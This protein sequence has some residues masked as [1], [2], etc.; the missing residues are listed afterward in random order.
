MRSLIPTVWKSFV[1]TEKHVLQKNGKFILRQ[2]KKSSRTPHGKIGFENLAKTIGGRWKNIPPKKLEK[3]KA[4][5]DQDMQRY[6][7]EMEE[8]HS[9]QA[10]KRKQAEEEDVRQNVSL[11][12]KRMELSQYLERELNTVEAHH[13]VTVQLEEERR[14]RL[15][16]LISN[17]T[18]NIPPAMMNPSLSTAAERT[19]LPPILQQMIQR[20]PQEQTSNVSLVN[21]LLAN[22]PSSAELFLSQLQASSGTSL[23]GL[24]ANSN[25]TPRLD[26]A[27]LQDSI[28]KRN[29]R[30]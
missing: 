12:I 10:E 18:G 4:L 9:S 1:K 21:S 8:Y 30:F 5:A 7:S 14:R 16:G 20:Q 26:Y 13:T 28:F 27:S 3:Y 2:E 15:E 6:N 29:E 19:T 11:E 22:G 23:G 24:P 17:T 25:S